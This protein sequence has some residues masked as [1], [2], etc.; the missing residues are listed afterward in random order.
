M[1]NIAE[2]ASSLNLSETSTTVIRQFKIDSRQV[3]PGDVF[4]AFQ[5]QV[6][7]GHDFAKSA[8]QRGAVAII[9]ER[10]LPELNIPVLVVENSFQAVT[11][12]ALAHRQK[13]KPLVLAL[14]GSNGKTTVKEFLACIM[15]EPKY[16]SQGNF[17]N[18]LG[19]PLNI[20]NMPQDTQYAIFELGAS[21]AGDIAYTAAMVKPD[22]A[23]IN[24]I[25]PAHLSGFGSINGVAIA[26]GEIYQSLPSTGIA[27][28]NA[29]DTYAHFWDEIIG[30]RA[31]IRFSS[32]EPAD[33]WANKIELQP[34]GC[35]A[36]QLNIGKHSAK[37]RL[38][39][40]GRHQVQNALAAAAM[41]TAAKRGMQEIV[42]GLERFQ[43]VKGRMNLL[44]GHQ[45]SHIIDD[46]YNANLSSVKAGLDYLAGRLGE[47]IL[48]LG[49]LA[50]LGQYAEE[51]HQ[52]VGRIA[53]NL[54]INQLL[55]LGQSTPWAVS[56]FGSGGRH[57]QNSED[58]ITYLK[59]HLNANTHV[60][61]K[62]SRSARMEEIVKK[63]IN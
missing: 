6:Q 8:Q 53:K 38:G 48:V 56:A 30:V 2:L 28:V 1:M 39:V 36:F 58:L 46:T 17:N 41:A 18:Q 54:G 49:D 21:Q 20:L 43:G 55:A 14:T 47:K 22:I 51:Q 25:G 57:F 52:E 40:A 29:D 4:I 9:A 32:Q 60:L 19:V 13:I 34:N 3:E 10:E 31:I 35:Y 45:Q 7:D 59:Q 44:S 11:Q 24:N 33:I 61:I 37:V 27:V 23:L 5:G 26:K 50:E 15:P 16:A 42:V 62:G 63:I 12:A